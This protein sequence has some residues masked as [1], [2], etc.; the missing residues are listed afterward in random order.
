[1]PDLPKA[2]AVLFAK[3]LPRMAQFYAGVVGLVIVHSDAD[4]IVLE[5]AHQQLVLHGI[6]KHIARSIRIASPPVRREDTAVKL[7][8]PVASLAEARDKAATLGGE[9]N[10]KKKEFAARGFLACD[11]HDP[12]GNVVQFRQA[13]LSSG[14]AES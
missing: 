3:D 11:G 10:P 9:L 12:E 2:G 1:M 4:V 5:S 7:V 8:F 13:A 14:V 6:P